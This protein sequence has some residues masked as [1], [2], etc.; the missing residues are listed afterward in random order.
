MDRKQGL[1]TMWQAAARCHS[2]GGTATLA[3]WQCRQASAGHRSR[4]PLGDTQR[5]QAAVQGALAEAQVGG[6]FLARAAE[7]GVHLGQRYAGAAQRHA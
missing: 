7:G 2:T 3:A 1:G 4:L 5:F 6:Q